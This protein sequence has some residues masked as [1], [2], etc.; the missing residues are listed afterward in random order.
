MH[1]HLDCKRSWW[2]SSFCTS[3]PRLIESGLSH[4]LSVQ[5]RRNAN[6]QVFYTSLLWYYLVQPSYHCL[7]DR[8]LSPGI[9]SIATVDSITKTGTCIRCLVSFLEARKKHTLPYQRWMFHSFASTN[10]KIQLADDRSCVK[11][12]LRTP[13]RATTCHESGRRPPRLSPAIGVIC[14]SPKQGE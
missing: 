5:P 14:I 9:D 4:I 1:M 13:R 10:S 6:V 8:G 11:A 3:N 2:D 12:R 7:L